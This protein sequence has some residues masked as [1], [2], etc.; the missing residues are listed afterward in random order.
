MG[1]KR[2]IPEVLQYYRRHGENESQW[3]VNRTS[4]VSRGEVQ[5]RQWKGHLAAVFGKTDDVER[6]PP[7]AQ[8]NYELIREWAQSATED[9]SATYASDLQHLLE[10]VDRRAKAL[11]RREEIRCSGFAVRLREVASASREGTYKNFSG[12]KSALRD[13]VG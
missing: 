7:V 3:I 2:V 10:Q 1:R 8:S 6:P 12:W 4:R 13:L 5:W 9:A 11:A